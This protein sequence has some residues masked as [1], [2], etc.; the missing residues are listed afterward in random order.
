MRGV[1]SDKG[2]GMIW[3]TGDKH[4]DF[5][6]VDD[7][8]R[9]ERTRREDTLIVLGDAGINYFP[10]ARATALKQ[11][12]AQ[13]PITL[14]CVHGN[15]EA[16]PETLRAYR[17]R[18]AFGGEAY[19]DPRYPN[20]LF[21][22]DGA[23][24]DIGGLRTLVVGGAYS[25]DKFDRLLNHWAW[26]EDEQPS[27]AIR[28]RAEA[29]LRAAG[30]RVDAVLSHTCPESVMPPGRREAWEAAPCLPPLVRGPLPRGSAG[31]RL[32]LPLPPIPALRRL[33]KGAPPWPANMSSTSRT[34]PSTKRRRSSS[35]T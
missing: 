24:Y 14:F 11:H 6:E 29:A 17:T 33:T 13:L 28:A 3:V 31:R 34:S 26:F 12:L 7:F 16:R 4:G 32:H 18:P 2:T 10:D 19:A 8:C 15:H 35:T 5:T 9:R 20:Q 1:R 23:L 30:W 25:V 22:V 27:P 21:P